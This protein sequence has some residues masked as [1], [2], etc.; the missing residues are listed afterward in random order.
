[1]DEGWFFWKQIVTPLWFE[2]DPV[3]QQSAGSPYLIYHHVNRI[4]KKWENA[5]MPAKYAKNDKTAWAE[6]KFAQV[7]LTADQK[8][9]FHR[10]WNQKA[11][12]VPLE[13]STMIANGWKAGLTWDDANKCF[14]ASA[15]CK[16]ERS[17]NANVCV[18]SRSDDY[19][20]ALLLNVYKVNVLFK[21][22]PLPTERG[23]NT[24]G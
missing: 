10:W 12:D 3:L 7:T 14:I 11:F 16:D 18:T 22:Q 20:E 5:I 17:V 4:L 8:D 15:T 6:T 1:M 21:N 24:W 13:I 19:T 2:F 9:E 23:G